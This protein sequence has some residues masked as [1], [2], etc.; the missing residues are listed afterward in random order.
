M[1]TTEF[2]WDDLLLYL[3]EQRV[4]PVLGQDLLT[5]E[6]SGQTA[7][8]Y[9]L[10]GR[11]LLEDLKIPRDQVPSES[12]L[13]RVVGEYPRFRE[14]RGLVYTHTR[15]A[16]ER[17]NLPIPTP[18]RLLARISA[19]QLFITTTFDP[20]MGRALDEERFGGRAQTIG[21]AYTPEHSPDISSEQLR[22]GRPIV[23]QLF[24]RICSTPH[25]AVTEEDM[26]EYLHDLQENSPKL[27]C[28]ELRNKHL[29]FIGNAFPDWLARF[30]IRT[31]RGKRF[32]DQRGMDEFVVENTRSVD[33]PLVSF[34]N[35]F[36]RETNFYS[37]GTPEEFVRSLYGRW[38]ERHP[39]T[40]QTTALSPVPTTPASLAAVTGPCVFISYAS[41]N[42]EAVRRLRDALSEAGV[43]VWV[44][45][46]RLQAGETY[47]RN[48]ER[49]VRRCA[50]FMPVISQ[51]TE[52]RDEGFFRKEWGWALKRLPEFTGSRRPFIVPVMIDETRFEDAQV[53]DEFKTL[54][55]SRAPG[56]QPDESL[57]SSVRRI[58]RD[59]AKQERLPA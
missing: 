12:S 21:I 37:E 44:D 56:G 27:L 20:W 34:F 59:L 54:H 2:F 30:F 5:V 8:A 38:Q 40:S 45:L 43:S 25:Y 14:K 7:N 31:V 19:F 24:G 48:I 41:Q 15:N 22:S 17:L 11:R 3:E 53:P 42:V 32:I 39:T 28:D 52:A 23:F 55:A 46:D 47:E 4:I 58:V 49:N 57:L 16:F 18:L 36:S 35:Q 6:V 51:D 13:S 10:L 1:K 26:L 9:C 33:E 50:L 29:L